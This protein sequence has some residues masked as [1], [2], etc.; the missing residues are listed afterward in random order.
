VSLTLHSSTDLYA[1]FALNYIQ[2]R[3]AG[4][5]SENSDRSEEKFGL[6]QFLVCFEANSEPNITKNRGKM[7]KP[8]FFAVG[9]SV[10]GQPPRYLIYD[11]SI[12]SRPSQEFQPDIKS[13]NF[14]KN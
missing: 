11:I 7:T 3:L 4:R 8:S 6:W 2:V 1:G 13:D 5:L 10:L 9:G 14:V 12:D